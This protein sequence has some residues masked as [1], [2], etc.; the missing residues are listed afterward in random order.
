MNTS[1][2][3]RMSHGNE[4]WMSHKS[5]HLADFD[6]DFPL[7]VYC[8]IWIRHVTYA[9]VMG[10]SHEWVMS[11][12]TSDDFKFDLSWMGHVTYEYV[13][14]H[15]HESWEWVMNESWV[16]SPLTISSL[17]FH[18]MS[19]VTYEYVMSHMHGS[20]EWVM[21][22]SWVMSPLTIS[23]L[24]FHGW[25]MSHMNTSCHICMSH[26]NESCMGW[27]RSVGSIK[28]YTSFAE[29]RLFYRALLQKRPII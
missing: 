24:T 10:M 25:V 18:W 5:C 21:N 28:L 12:V 22:E 27:L 2:H 6:F 16:M 15:M 3:I 13:M 4:S 1:C 26:E 7:D 29:Y 8:H 20:W 14:S 9:W 23:S 19:H 11:Q 17:T